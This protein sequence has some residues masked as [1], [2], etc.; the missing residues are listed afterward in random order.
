MYARSK[1]QMPR[2]FRRHPKPRTF[3]RLPRLPKRCSNPTS[4]AHV[5]SAQIP[6][7]IPCLNPAR[8]RGLGAC[9]GYKKGSMFK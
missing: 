9:L 1:L 5:P 7:P 3:R 8:A 2:T 6:D 4:P